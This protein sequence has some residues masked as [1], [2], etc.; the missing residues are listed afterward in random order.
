[1]KKLCVVGCSV[2]DY[3]DVEFPYGHL[4]ANDLG[5]EYLHEGAGA[6]SNY[7]IWRRITNHILDGKITS[8]DILIIQYT[9]V[10]RNEF[11]SALPE[12]TIP[13]TSP[14]AELSHDNGRVLRWKFGSHVW[15]SHPEEQRFFEEYEKYFVS[16]RFAQEQFRVNNYNFQMMLKAHNIKAIFLTTSRSTLTGKYLIEP[17]ES[18]QVYDKSNSE[19]AYNLREGDTCHFSQFGHRHMADKLIERIK[20]LKWA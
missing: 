10:V 14:P 9:E 5:L 20:E 13:Y 11:W 4:I 2:S 3:T 1:V 12:P 16:P 6:G 8:D 7:R 18:Y 17:F 19:P 15:Q